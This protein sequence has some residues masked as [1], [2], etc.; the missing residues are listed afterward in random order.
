MH[1]CMRE[2]PYGCEGKIACQWQGYR[3]SAA[4]TRTCTIRLLWHWCRWFKWRAQRRST[5]RGSPPVSWFKTSYFIQQIWPSAWSLMC[6]E[7]LWRASLCGA[8]AQLS[9]S[10]WSFMQQATSNNAAWAYNNWCMKQLVHKTVATW[11][12]CYIYRLVARR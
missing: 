6:P 7:H 3:M 10:T 12:N 8:S 5:Q 11:N 1:M 4:R 9:V 2:I